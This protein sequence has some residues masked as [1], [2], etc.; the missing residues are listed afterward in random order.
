MTGE[1][2]IAFHGRLDRTLGK[3][4]TFPPD[5]PE[6]GRHPRQTQRPPIITL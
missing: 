2:A 4:G 5:L 1:T 6:S 3:S